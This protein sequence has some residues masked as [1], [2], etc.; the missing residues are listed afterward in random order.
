ML[1]ERIIVCNWFLL[2]RF[3][4]F[5][6]ALRLRFRRSHF[7]VRFFLLR[8]L[9]RGLFRLFRRRFCRC[10]CRYLYRCFRGQFRWKCFGLEH[11]IRF[12]SAALLH[13]FQ[14]IHFF[15]LRQVRSQHRR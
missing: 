13:L 12:R 15:R 11:C 14:Q 6:H 7:I 8:C 1:Q 2:C 4:F 10:F 3:G 9:R 5:P